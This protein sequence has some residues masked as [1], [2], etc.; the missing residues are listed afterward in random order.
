MQQLICVSS[1]RDLCWP[2]VFRIGQK[3]K[4][5]ATDSKNI[6]RPFVISHKMTVFHK[7]NIKFQAAFCKEYR[8]QLKKKIVWL[9]NCSSQ[10]QTG[11][12]HTTCH[13]R[14]V[15]NIA[16]ALL[17]V[18]PSRWVLRSQMTK[19]GDIRTLCLC[20]YRMRVDIRAS[21]DSKLCRVPH[22]RNLLSIQ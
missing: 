19:S 15:T 22:N 2:D 16:V 18:R 13:A 11:L 14:P 8:L 7:T 6:R 5:V 3:T 21:M 20:K 9:H 1:G 10:Y 12:F 17:H 4:I